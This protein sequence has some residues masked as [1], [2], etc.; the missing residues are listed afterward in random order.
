MPRRT[1]LHAALLALSFAGVWAGACTDESPTLN[2]DEFFPGG[3][4]PVTRE[5]ILPASQFFTAIGSFSDYA[6][7]AN[8]GFVVVAED[9]AGVLD[10]H[11]LLSFTETF[12]AAASYVAEGRQEIDSTYTTGSGRLVMRVDSAETA[13]AGPVTLRAYRLVQDFDVQTATWELAADTN[14]TEVA[15]QEPGGTRAELLAQIPYAPSEAGD[16]IVF[17]L[18]SLEVQLLR[19]TLNPSGLVITSATPGS[20]VQIFTATGAVLRT[21]LHP[22]KAPTAVDTVDVPIGRSTFVFTPGLPETSAAAFQAGGIG[23]ARTLFTLNLAQTVPNCPPPQACAGVPLSEVEVNRVSLLLRRLPVPGGF[24]PLD[25][26]ALTLRNIREPELGR[27]APLGDFVLDRN[28]VVSPGRYY[29]L[30]PADTVVELPLSDYAQQVASGDT[31]P[32]SFALLSEP[33]FSFGLGYFDPEPRL[34][35]VY[36]LPVR[37]RLP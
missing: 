18:D 11:A 23:S 21:R 10:A 14:G 32:T 2:G 12:P 7:P 8:A 36:T 4:R 28:P 5:V 27:R 31:V 20:R 34:R 29:F 1:R 30:S 24:E 15:W 33:G 3:S 25:T 6:G 16:S 13:A 22:S 37:P 26:I 9:Y 17:P 19:D 35:I